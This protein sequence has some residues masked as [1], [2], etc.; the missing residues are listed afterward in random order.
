MLNVELIKILL[1]KQNLSVYKLSKMTNIAEGRLSYILNKKTPNPRIA[2]VA[3]IAKALG[4]KV[5]DLLLD[6]YK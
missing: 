1:K 2:T 4:V 6:E 3:K 5:D